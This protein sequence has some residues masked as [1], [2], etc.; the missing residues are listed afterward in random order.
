M[1]ISFWKNMIMIEE[2]N[3]YERDAR[4]RGG[5]RFEADIKLIDEGKLFYKS[6]RVMQRIAGVI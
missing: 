1:V 4:T 3:G 2:H 6:L 5:A